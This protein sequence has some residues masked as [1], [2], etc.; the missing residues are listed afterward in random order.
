MKPDNPE[1]KST[2]TRGTELILLAVL[3]LIVVLRTSITETLSPQSAGMPGNYIPT[4]GIAFSGILI[5]AAA[6]WLAV[7]TLQGKI[8][9]RFTGMEIPAVLFAVAAVISSI[10]AANK[11]AAVTDSLNLISAVVTAILIAQLLDT[12][13][14]IK[15]V[16][17]IIAS[18]GAV[19]AYQCFEQFFTGN[20]IMIQQYEESPEYFLRQIGI[21]QGTLQQFLFEHRLY[22]MG[23]RGF[24]STANSAGSFL[25]IAV[26]AALAAAGR[27][28]FRIKKMKFEP[29]SLAGILIILFL[30]AALFLT[31]SKGA[32]MAF[33][34]AVVCFGVYLKFSGWL[35]KYRK[36]LGIL[37]L[38]A[39]IFGGGAVITYGIMFDKLPGGKSM[40]V[41]WQYWKA[42]AQMYADHF[43]LGVG[44]GN[45]AHYY[46]HYKPAAAIESVANPH[47]FILN[48]LTQY[49][50]AGLIG[51]ST[52]IFCPLFRIFRSEKNGSDQPVSTNENFPMLA[53]IFMII[54]GA[55]LLI[56]KSLIDRTPLG[57]S[58]A[59]I[60]YVFF[61]IYAIPAVVF[62]I[63]FR[64]L[65]RGDGDVE[66]GYIQA[67]LIC[68]V[69]GCLLHNLV[70]FAIFEGGLLTTFFVIIGVV[71]A[72][73]NIRS[74]KSA[75]IYKM[76][77]PVKIITL[78]VITGLIYLYFTNAFLPVRN[79]SR[80][81]RK[82][83]ESGNPERLLHKAGQADPL[84]PAPCYL[85][86]KFYLRNYR[87]TDEKESLEE[88]VRSYHTAIKRDSADY[89]NY[90]KLSIVYELLGNNE[91]AYEFAGQAISRYPGL[92]RL[93]F[94]FAQIAEKLNKT[95]AAVRGYKKAVEIEGKYRKQFKRM[96]PDREVFS[97]LGEQKYQ[98]ARERLNVLQQ[99][100]PDESAD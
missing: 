9:Y 35:Y 95:E 11:R 57:Y 8:I 59:V 78:L 36:P 81:I 41:R 33:V 87:Q 22:S 89:K 45:F 72:A 70:D 40:F 96:Y 26:F 3:M 94:R 61:V 84:D 31:R 88:A 50:I 14:K 62:L 97:R 15:L 76:R 67:A 69:G 13:G 68:A 77:P 30:A 21:E 27:S 4:A 85:E 43:L 12:R 16:L 2:F 20:E 65:A 32:V 92:G 29:D 51:F 66:C 5:A 7:C 74:P 60:L 52:V 56:L 79:S 6:V 18:M 37:F 91:K 39:V 73:Y 63:S 83:F 24:F 17:I 93:W 44:P 80:L 38:L 54:C 19:N 10:F 28:F 48:I 55:G 82:S 99:N 23:I 75:R 100:S 34:V 86:G 42:S 47:N 90:E 64:L 71:F 49:G 25:I 53:T 98:T 1:Q 46:T 58:S